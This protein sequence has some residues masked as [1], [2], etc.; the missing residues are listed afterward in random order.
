MAREGRAGG[1]QQGE[2]G[3]DGDDGERRAETQADH[4]GRAQEHR[5]RED[6]ADGHQG[7]FMSL[8]EIDDRTDLAPPS[9]RDVYGAQRRRPRDEQRH[10]QEQPGGTRTGVAAGVLGR[11]E[12]DPESGDDA[13]YGAGG[14]HRAHDG[15]EQRTAP[16]REIERSERDIPSQQVL[17]HGRPQ[18]R[19]APGNHRDEGE[20][21]DRARGARLEHE[22]GRARG[23]HAAGGAQGDTYQTAANGVVVQDVAHV[24]L[25]RRPDLSPG[26]RMYVSLPL[27]P[28]KRPHPFG[29]R[30]D[31]MRLNHLHLHVADLDRASTFWCDA[32]GLAR[33]RRAGDVQF[34]N[35]DA[36]FDLA[37][38]EEADPVALPEPL[39]VGFR[40]GS[41]MEVEQ[42]HD[43][44][45][46]R[47][48]ELAEPLTEEA[49]M[50]WF[51]VADP[52]GHLVEIY[53]ERAAP[54][55]C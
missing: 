12:Q 39:H 45:L 6:H 5:E 24:L 43:R 51:R 41:V 55:V 10:G 14:H 33:G 20:Q 28:G 47:G 31:P 27:R 37:L 48:L 46:R 44:L 36:G 42:L 4:A 7:P 18:G 22:Q 30:E 11:E 16:A 17:L 54:P 49:D 2:S 21:G 19:T 50:V 29:A 35:D 40:L 1:Q 25:P 53:W 38:Y 26:A 23:R 32:L 3:E 52:D 13:E 9:E 34:L 15:G 8:G